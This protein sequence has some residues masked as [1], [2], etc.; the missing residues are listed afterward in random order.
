MLIFFDI[1]FKFK[2]LQNRT[3]CGEAHV[4]ASAHV[5]KCKCLFCVVT[6][7]ILEGGY[8]RFGGT[9]WLRVQFF[10][11]S[12][13]ASHNFKADFKTRF[14]TIEAEGS[15][16]HSQELATGL[17]PE[18]DESCPHP[19]TLLSV[20]SILISTYWSPSSQH[21]MSKLYTHFSPPMRTTCSPH[22]ILHDL[23]NLV[24]V[25]EEQK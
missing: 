22:F 17:Y 18:P 20:R 8:R 4:S 10:M 13:Y 15:L 21:F 2:F 9:Y 6:L 24:I 1:Y 14:P 11:T 16:P 23:T 19:P 7:Y 12:R 3:Q 5:W 25:G